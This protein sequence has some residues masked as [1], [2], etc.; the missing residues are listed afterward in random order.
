MSESRRGGTERKSRNAKPWVLA[1]LALV[2]VAVAARIAVSLPSG[3]DHD[4]HAEPVPGGHALARYP[5]PALGTLHNVKA[6]A[7]QVEV[8]SCDALDEGGQQA[9][10]RVTNDARKAKRYQITVYFLDGKTPINYAQTQVSVPPGGHVPWVVEKVFAT[11][12]DLT[13]KVVAVG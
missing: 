13:C 4:R 12:L 6:K 8:S 3:G 10:G 7:E 9:T 2:A 5:V 11:D 1:A